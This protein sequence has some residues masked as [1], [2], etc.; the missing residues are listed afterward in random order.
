MEAPYQSGSLQNL[1]IDEFIPLI[2]KWVSSISSRQASRSVTGTMP[3]RRDDYSKD[4]ALQ[5][6]HK[7]R[8]V[9]YE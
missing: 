2:R 3:R 5:K 1:N 4:S 7:S 9:S 8:G 6:P